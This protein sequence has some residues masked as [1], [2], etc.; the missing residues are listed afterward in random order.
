MDGRKGSRD[1]EKIGPYSNM[2]L[3]FSGL[4]SGEDG[5]KGIETFFS[6]ASA[7][8]ATAAPAKKRVNVNEGEDRA[9]KRRKEDEE[10]VSLPTITCSRCAK[11]STL[12]SDV[13]TAL[14]PAFDPVAVEAALERM[15]NEHED[16]HFG[17][18]LLEQE[19]KDSR[20][21]TGVIRTGS[22]TS[23][24][25]KGKAVEGKKKTVGGQTSLQ[26]FF[27]RY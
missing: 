27:K 3:T 19:L 15:K 25:K 22:G 26:G 8:S 12:S 16:Y 13:V 11:V 20:A 6:A 2:Q 18:D 7:P 21:S 9:G 23:G 17:R 4:E 5:Q 24:S 10:E 14:R 1:E